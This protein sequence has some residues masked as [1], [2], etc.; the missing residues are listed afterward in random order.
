MDYKLLEVKRLLMII[1]SLHGGGDTPAELALDADFMIKSHGVDK[2][3]RQLKKVMEDNKWRE[4]S[5]NF[6]RK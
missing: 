2:V 3:L 6:K 1:S 4:K 5:E